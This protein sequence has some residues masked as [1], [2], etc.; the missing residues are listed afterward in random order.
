VKP[1]NCSVT[2]KWTIY[3]LLHCQASPHKM[4]RVCILTDPELVLSVMVKTGNCVRKL[5]SLVQANESNTLKHIL[6]VYRH[7]YVQSLCVY[8]IP[9]CYQC[10]EIPSLLWQR[11]LRDRKGFEPIKEPMPFI[12]KHSLPQQV[13]KES[14]GG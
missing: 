1:F 2:Q 4:L 8:N 12:L 14:Y 5:R 7:K 11:W 10:C 13:K 9:G 3:T 6:H